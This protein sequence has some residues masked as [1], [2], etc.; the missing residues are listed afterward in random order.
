MNPRRMLLLAALPALLLACATPLLALVLLACD[1]LDDPSPGRVALADGRVLFGQILP[2]RRGGSDDGTVDV[3]VGAGRPG[4][5]AMSIP[6]GSVRSFE[7]DASVWVV[8]RDDGPT[9]FGVPVSVSGPGWSLG[10]TDSVMK[11]VVGLPGRLRRERERLADELREAAGDSNLFASRSEG[12][13]RWLARDDA[14]RLLLDLGEGR[15]ASIRVS[16]IV[17]AWPSGSMSASRFLHR[18]WLFVSTS[19]GAWGGGGIRSAIASVLMLALMAGVFSG[20]FG[21]SAAVWIHSRSPGEIWLERGKT[22]VAALAGVPGVVWGVAGAGLLVH[23]LG[24]VLDRAFGTSLWSGG[25]LLWSGATLGAL[26]S[27]IVMA[28]AMEELDRI[29]VRWK[30]IA[31]SCGATRLQVFRRIVLPAARRGLVA[32]VL[33]G[34]ARAAGETAPLLLT[35][36]VRFFGGDGAVSRM[37]G[38]FLHPGVLALDSP[39]SGADL[40]RG[41]PRV[42]LMLLVLAVFCI[43]LDLAASRLR[44][45]SLPPREEL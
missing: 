31:W 27:P 40:E 20:I 42:A 9:L 30:E 23:G 17:S 36:A 25:G 10:R 33:S 38:G 26:A 29:P 13:E 16:G 11:A 21:L 45:R 7:R 22:L 43:G 3:L 5:A 44:R 18:A 24:P 35:G 39:W 8:E 41:Q 37:A 15:S 2:Q 1:G 34:M 28:L 6:R 14:T 19:P 12:W 32:A 4:P